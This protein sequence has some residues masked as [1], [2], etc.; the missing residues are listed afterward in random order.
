MLENTFW[1]G[2]CSNGEEKAPVH[3]DAAN[4]PLPLAEYQE[5]MTLDLFLVSS[6]I[7]T[8]LS[9]GFIFST[10]GHGTRASIGSSRTNATS[11]IEGG[12]A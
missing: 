9:M 3:L 12:V 7:P 4:A 5:K 8:D 1:T 2:F 10:T 11:E 6:A